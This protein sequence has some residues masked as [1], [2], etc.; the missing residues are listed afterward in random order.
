MTSSPFWV[1][2]GEQQFQFVNRLEDVL[3][4]V[5]ASVTTY[6]LYNATFKEVELVGVNKFHRLYSE[7]FVMASTFLTG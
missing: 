2:H 5:L 4:T 7:V 1:F 3:G 6:T